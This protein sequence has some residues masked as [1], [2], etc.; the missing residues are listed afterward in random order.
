MC[1]F[2]DFWYPR[3]ADFTIF[4]T[5]VLELSLIRSH[6]PWGEFSAFSA[7]N[8]I[9]NFPFFVPPGTHYHWMDRGSIEWEVFPT[10]LHMTSSGNRTSIHWTTRSH[11]KPTVPHKSNSSL[12]V[13]IACY[14][15][16]C[17]ISGNEIN[18]YFRPHKCTTMM[19]WIT[20]EYQ[21]VLLQPHKW[22]IMWLN[23]NRMSDSATAT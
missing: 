14:L 11:K 12:N 19:I 5:L 10:L 8:D 3:S 1:I 6:L 9:H 22:T 18:I 15:G 2:I 17:F 20:I 23:N 7:A 21:Q 13:L 16:H 4:T